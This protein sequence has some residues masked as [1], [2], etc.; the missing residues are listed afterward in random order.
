MLVIGP[1]PVSFSALVLYHGDRRLL[2]RA[3][4]LIVNLFVGLLLTAAHLILRRFCFRAELQILRCLIFEIKLAELYG[5]QCVFTV[6]SA[7]ATREE[8]RVDRLGYRPRRGC[9][10]VKT[11]KK[12]VGTRAS[13]D[14]GCNCVNATNRSIW[15]GSTEL[16]FILHNCEQFGNLSQKL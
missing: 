7:L 4:Y 8:L 5:L 15:R 13:L 1:V 16:G 2:K 3:G 9:M 11:G 12:L 14:S 10:T 6:I